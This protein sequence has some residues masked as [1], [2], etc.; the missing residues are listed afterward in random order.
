[1]RKLKEVLLVDDD[2]VNNFVSMRLLE[3]LEISEVVLL[4]KNGKEALDTI[5]KKCSPDFVCPEFII[6]D[7]QM[8]VMDGIE[9]M[10]HLNNMN[11]SNR[12]KIVILIL[13]A[14]SKQEDLDKFKKLG[15]TE[16]TSKPLS[17]KTVVNVYKKYW[18]KAVSDK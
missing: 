5:Q 14:A 13:A 6:L 11:F 9:F 7:H 8:P 17:E 10:E 15:V 12:N 16:F 1:M 3:K 4:A 2:E 18:A